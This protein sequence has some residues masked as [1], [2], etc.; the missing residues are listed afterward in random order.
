MQEQPRIPIKWTIRDVLEWTA[1]YFKS[2]GIRT[3][4]LDAE[5]LLAHCLGKDRLHLYLNLDRP[6]IPEERFRYREMV[7]RRAMREPVSLIIERKEF[8]SLPFRVVSG[9]LIPRPD[10]EI[11]VEEVLA[12]IQDIPFPEILEIGTGSGAVAV[13]VAHER[14]EASI[15]ATDI[16]RKALQTALINAR[17]AKASVLFLGASLMT[18]IRIEAH[19]DV[20]CSN[21][22]Y[23]PDDVIPTLEP[24]ITF[25]PLSA[26]RGG[27]DGL[28]IIRALVPQAR[29]RLK[30]TG[31]L[32]LEMDPAQ[33]AAVHDILASAGFTKIKTVLDLSGKPRVVKGEF[34]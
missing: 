28:D 7:R 10:T 13:A 32:I 33:E 23:I 8:W 18:P 11:L 19:F 22:P 31:A 12:T 5:V 17:Q 2:K 14:P 9:V 3:P 15:V 27:P 30:K 34:S 4:R 24:E 25:E 29:D 16:D 20:I 6:M 26:L 21:P 1:T